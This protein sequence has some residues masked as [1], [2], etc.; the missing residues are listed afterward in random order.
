M[1]TT[2][3][4]FRWEH[5]AFGNDYMSM[6]TTGYTGLDPHTITHN[7]ILPARRAQI[8][9]RG[10]YKAGLA[11]LPDGRL[12][13]SPVNILAEKIPSPFPTGCVDVTWPVQLYESVDGGLSW[14]RYE[15]SPLAGKEGSL[16]SLPSGVLLFSSESLD[17]ICISEDEGR[18]WRPVQ[19]ETEPR[20]PYEL[21]SATRS[22]IIHAD[23]TISILRCTGTAEH[24]LEHATRNCRAWLFTSTDGGRTWNDRT[25]VQMDWEDPFPLF[26]ECDFE[27]LP[28]GR[29]L[30]CSRFEWNAALKDQPLPYA[31]G[32][33][34]NDHA[35]GHMVLIESHDRGRTWSAPRDFLGYSKVQGQLTLLRDGRLLC[36][37]TNYHLPFGVAAVVSRDGGKT[38][39]H[40]HPF[41]LAMSNGGSTGWATTRQ[42]PDET[43]VTIHA[44]EPYHI[45]PAE[46]GKTV[47]HSVKWQMPED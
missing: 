22:P 4:S 17:G 43:L 32:A 45:E 29:I 1:V 39:D 16:H 47:C 11:V 31:P 6:G 21:T 14:Q 42:L 13:A 27:C 23:G 19:L 3:Q 33:M 18:N 2:E 8:G 9:P 24:D 46:T 36:T 40:S 7:T 38:W 15:H 25:E 30:A 10:M 35:A 44:L 20:H 34:P 12:L 26:A 5:D 41:Q 28:D 37:Y